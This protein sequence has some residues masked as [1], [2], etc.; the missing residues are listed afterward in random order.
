LLT[1]RKSA[2]ICWKISCVE[3]AASTNVRPDVVFR[4]DQDYGVF[5]YRVWL[6]VLDGLRVARKRVLRL[7]RENGR[8]RIKWME[9]SE[10][11]GML[12]YLR[13]GS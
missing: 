13:Q 4:S 3:W 2:P 8:S 7:M 12:V 5:T 6:R 10:P 9:F 11:T 1:K